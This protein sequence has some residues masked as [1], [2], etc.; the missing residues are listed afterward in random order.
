MS[1]LPFAL[2]TAAGSV[3]LT[4]CASHEARHPPP[5]APPTAVSVVAAHTETLDVLHRASGTV[6]G[7]STAVITSKTT[8]YV[9]QVTVRPGDRVRAGQ[10]LAVL[11]AKDSAASARRA[12]AGLDTATQTKGEAQHSLEV[13]RIAANSAK[14]TRDRVVVLAAGGSVSKQELDDADARWREAAAQEQVAEARLRSASSRIAQAGAEMA[15]AQTMLDYARIIAPF[16]GRVIERR[17][18]P[19][20]MASPG[21]PLL[22]VED[23]VSLRVEASVGESFAAAIAMGD[24]ATVWADALSQPVRANVGEIVPS[25]DLASRAF[26]VKVDL[27]TSVTGLRAGMFAR[28]EFK[29]GTRARLVVPK[30][31]VTS[32]G[33]LDRV[34]VVD[35][36]RARLRMIAVGDNQG[37]WTEVLSGLEAGERIVV[38]PATLKDGAR[39]DVK[40]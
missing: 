1:R 7:K 16:D 12:G 4:A 31:S 39:V 28:V 36:Q 20:S 24:E 22:V 34:L 11:E 40:P 3:V 14:T 37:E 19:G 21:V 18:D 27:P 6:R 38:A 8:G 15:E 33:A 30:A 23:D 29:V 26:I 9:R 13:A 35:G 10:L 17:I 32:L 5:E 25:I 2:L